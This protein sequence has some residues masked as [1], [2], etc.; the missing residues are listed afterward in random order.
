M[1]GFRTPDKKTDNTETSRMEKP[2]TSRFDPLSN[3][4]SHVRKS[5]GEW[6]NGKGKATQSPTESTEVERTRKKE[7]ATKEKNENVRRMSSE[8][9]V[10]SP[11]KK[12]SKIAEAKACVTKAKINLNMSRNIKTEI[13]TGVAEAI[14][15]LYG[16]VKEMAKEMEK[17]EEK[18][19]NEK[20]RKRENLEKQKEKEKEQEQD[21]E[22]EKEKESVLIKKMEEHAKLIE[23]SNA[24][25]RELNDN[26][27]KYQEKEKQTY[28]NVVTQNKGKSMEKNV[29]HSVVV[30]AKDENETGE[31]V[32]NRIRKA[33]N[34]KDG[35]IAVE[36]IRKAKD[37]KVIVGCRTEQD[38]KQLKER[39][40]TV[41]DHLEVQEIKN[42]NPLVI[43]RDVFKYNSDDDVLAALRNQNKNIFKNLEEEKMEIIYKRRARNPHA[44]HIVMRVAPQ[45]WQRMVDAERV[46][47]DLQRIRVEDQS[48]VIQCSTCLGYGHPKRLCKE[49]VEKCSHCGGPHKKVDCTDWLAGTDPTCCNCK[50]EKLDRADHNTFSHECP[51]RKRWDA[52]ARSA[53]SYC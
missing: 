48:P 28:A 13:K 27:E 44:N 39:L 22:K 20:E 49:Q 26:L 43:L 41:K 37:R 33:V 53:I 17:G 7:T 32:L 36:R 5:I 50:H 25:I 38:R 52:L 8:I 45:I 9:V 18:K 30:T 2:G 42:K 16:I 19:P 12:Q 10:I 15:R 3:K 46:Q 24:K 34:A 11:P 40:E 1:F 4:T 6:E 51:I 14:D 31:E 47:V 35:E 21:L 23:E 29:M